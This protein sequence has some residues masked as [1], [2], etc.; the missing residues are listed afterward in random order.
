MTTFLTYCRDI[1]RAEI[2]SGERLE[3]KDRRKVMNVLFKVYSYVA[4]EN[5]RLTGERI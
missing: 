2:A 5:W 3:K 1:K 4:L